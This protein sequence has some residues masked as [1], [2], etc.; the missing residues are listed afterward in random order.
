MC[1]HRASARHFCK[2]LTDHKTIQTQ[3]QVVSVPAAEGASAAAQH[4]CQS[5][6]SMLGFAGTKQGPRRRTWER[7]WDKREQHMVQTPPGLCKCGRGDPWRVQHMDGCSSC[8]SSWLALTLTIS[9]RVKWLC[10]VLLQPGV[11]AMSESSYSLCFG[12][13]AQLSSPAAHFQREPAKVGA[14]GLWVTAESQCLCGSC[15]HWALGSLLHPVWH[16]WPLSKGAALPS[17]CHGGIQTLLGS[18]PSLAACKRDRAVLPFLLCACPYL[19]APHSLNLWSWRMGQTDFLIL[20][21]SGLLF[22]RAWA[23]W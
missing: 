19:I 3:V 10:S 23:G 11:K 18:S 7:W 22:P 4:C 6:L 2:S 1:S 12:S 20:W 17:H 13:F 14:R 5:C 9:I 21:E 15:H 16:K 8:C